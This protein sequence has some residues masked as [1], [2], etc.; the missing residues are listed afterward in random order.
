MKVTCST[1]EKQT[2]GYCSAKKTMVSLNKRRKCPKYDHDVTKEKEYSP[3]P[4]EMR[5]D[6]YWD[7]KETKRLRREWR[8]KVLEEIK[9]AEEQKNKSEVIQPFSGNDKH[10]LT[11]DLSRFVSTV[12]NKEDSDD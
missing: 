7:K 9:K 11:G 3:I 5:P 12:S 2:N 10:P 8:A 1:C 4:S 6:W